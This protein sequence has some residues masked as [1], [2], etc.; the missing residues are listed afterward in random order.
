MNHLGRRSSKQAYHSASDRRQGRQLGDQALQ[1]FGSTHRP[2]PLAAG[3]RR[4]TMRLFAIIPLIVIG[5]SGPAF[6]ASPLPPPASAG[7]SMLAASLPVTGGADSTG[8]ASAV[9]PAGSFSTGGEL[10]TGGDSATGGTSASLSTSSQ[11]MGGGASGTGGASAAGTGGEN[12]TGGTSVKCTGAV[13]TNGCSDA[14]P[15]TAPGWSCSANDICAPKLF[16]ILHTC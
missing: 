4:E 6:E 5:C 16:C 14:P 1:S 13:I 7:A 11:P 12:S 10:S 9:S 2:A 15:T 3:D 8:G